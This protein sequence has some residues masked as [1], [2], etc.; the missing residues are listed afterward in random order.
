MASSSMNK[1]S[2]SRILA[3]Q[4]ALP[5]HSGFVLSLRNKRLA[6]LIVC[7]LPPEPLT[8]LDIGCGSGAVAKLVQELHPGTSLEGTDLL[9]RPDAL[10]PVIQTDGK[11]LP[12]AD[13]SFDFALLIDVLHHS[14]E[15]DLILQEALRVS[16]KFVIM[17]EPLQPAFLA[18]F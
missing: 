15:P 2:V 5:L 4:V 10:I 6:E 11:S 16:S 14:L 7:L 13:A 18:C 17:F 3:Q 1:F 12:Y 9:S 8:G